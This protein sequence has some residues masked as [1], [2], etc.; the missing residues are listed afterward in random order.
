VSKTALLLTAVVL[1]VIS[2][3]AAYTLPL[4]FHEIIAEPDPSGVSD[5]DLAAFKEGQGQMDP[6]SG[7]PDFPEDWSEQQRRAAQL[8]AEQEKI[9]RE[10]EA[11]MAGA[12]GVF[13]VI[14]II[15]FLLTLLTFVAM[16]VTLAKLGEPWWLMLIPIV[17]AFALPVMMLRVGGQSP[18]LVLLMIIPFLNIIVGIWMYYN[19]A[20]ALGRGIGTMLGL[21]FLPFIFWPILAVNPYPDTA[22]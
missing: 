17:N 5:A 15:A 4:L 6:G 7:A 20:T 19:F 9:R 21:I 16:C 12:A 13:V 10:M 14:W 18:W 11:A 1:F 22:A 3:V 8:R 2:A